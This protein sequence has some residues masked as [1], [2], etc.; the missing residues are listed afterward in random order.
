V[1]RARCICSLPHSPFSPVSSQDADAYDNKQA[2]T[3]LAEKMRKRDPTTAPAV[4]DRVPY[5]IVAASKGAKAYEKAEDP[6]YVLEND[7]P[8]DYEWY[9]SNLRGP[10][11]RIFEPIMPDVDSLF[12]G[13]HTTKITRPTPKSGGIVGFAIRREACIGCKTPLGAGESGICRACRP[14]LAAIY[15]AQLATVNTLEAQFGRVWTECQAC[16]GSFHQTV[17][18]TSRDCPIFYARKKVQKNLNDAHDV[19]AKFENAW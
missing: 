6:L 11:T 12:S 17:L 18:C 1:L 5:V 19:L 16:Q 2:H 9:I 15:A 4:G 13:A 14:N 3:E 7:I 10:V 8:L